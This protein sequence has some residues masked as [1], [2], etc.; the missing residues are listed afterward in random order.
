MTAASD[1]IERL[2]E[3]TGQRIDD[4][5]SLAMAGL[6]GAMSRLLGHSPPSYR[7]RDD[8]VAGLLIQHRMSP[9]YQAE[10][11]SKRMLAEALLS[12]ISPDTLKDITS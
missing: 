7:P 5:G 4:D 9:E 10:Q 1:L 11:A 3:E 8:V 2:E 12:G 6:F